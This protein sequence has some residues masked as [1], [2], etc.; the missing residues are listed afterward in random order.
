MVAAMIVGITLLGVV[1]GMQG[2]PPG[3]SSPFV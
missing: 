3:Y 1:I 2:E